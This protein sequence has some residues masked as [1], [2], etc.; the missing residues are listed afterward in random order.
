MPAIRFQPSAIKTNDGANAFTVTFQSNTCARVLRLAI[1]DFETDAPAIKKITLQDA[2]GQT[3]LPTSQDLMTLKRNLSIEIVPGDKISIT[4]DDPKFVTKERQIIEASMMATFHDASLSACFVE[5]TLDGSGNRIPQYIPMRRFKPDDTV[6][7]FISD[8]DEDSSDAT[9]KVTFTAR[10]SE[11]KPVTLDAVETGPHSGIFLGK[12]FPISVAPQRPSELTVVKGD[13]LIL[14][15][16][17]RENTDPGIP[18]NRNY[19][20]EQTSDR[21]PELRI[22]DITSLPLSSNEQAAVINP[23]DVRQYEEN[24]PV[25]RTIVENRPMEANRETPATGLMGIPM[26]VELTYPTIMQSPLSRASIYVQTSSGRKKYGKPLEGKFD[27]NVPGTVKL[28]RTPGDL[29]RI[30]PPPGYRDILVRGNPYA[31]NP[32]EDG[33]FCFLMPVKLDAIPDKTLAFDSEANKLAQNTRTDSLPTLSIRGGDEIFVGFQ[34]TDEAGATNWLVQSMI[35]TSDIFFDIMD[36]RYQKPLPA[37]H[38]GESIYLRL[39]DSARDIT[40]DKDA[41]EIQLSSASGTNQTLS[42]METFAHSGIFKGICQLIYSG[43]KNKAVETGSLPV[44]YGDTILA[45]YKST[46]NAEPQERTVLV[47]KGA[48][49]QVMPF[50]KRFKDPDIAVQTQ[51]TIAEAYFELAKKHRELAQESLARREIAQGKKLLDEA[52]RDYP[53][54]EA[55]AQADYLLAELSLEFANEAVNEDEK[56]KFYTEAISR[57]SDIV[58]SYPDSPHAPKAQYKKALVFEKTG[59]IDQ[60]CEEYVKLSYRYPDNELVAETIARL[61]QYF[62]AKGK[63]LVDKINAEANLVER[64]KLKMQAREMNRTAAQVFGRLAVRF[65]DH[66]L[67]GKTTVLSAQCYM[68]AEDMDEAIGVFKK[69]IESKKAEGDLIA[70]SMYWCGDC[71]MKKMDYTNAYRMFKKVT[72]DYPESTW[73]KYARGRLTEETLAAVETKDMAGGDGR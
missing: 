27:L 13:D 28:T 31:S 41:A 32:L 59:Q 34:Y 55:Q 21:V 52:I 11:G 67:A 73:A 45:R 51:F 35:P 7:V 16:M 9:D 2:N 39:I 12:V 64:E 44:R 42:L 40:D 36:C 46:G 65:P 63:A 10:T 72:W 14:S 70:Q 37:V 66:R 8:P 49:G 20:V 6:N 62:L 54:T 17:D 69:V 60:A 19:L 15:Y 25:T 68:R 4:Y 58:A 1:L 18:W 24:V 43:D 26:V 71:Y 5:S 22:Y 48:D 50:T 3:I 57:F 38:V 61:G 30:P 56:K 33:R 53:N 29:E 47:Y 23:V